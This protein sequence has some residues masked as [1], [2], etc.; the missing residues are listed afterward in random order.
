MWA[1][2]SAAD[3]VIVMTKLVAANPRRNRTTAFP[4]QRGNRFSSIRMLPWPNGLISATRLYIGSAPNTVTRTRISVAIGDS[5]P[6][7][8]KAMPGW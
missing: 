1:A 4:F 2:A 6:A 3:S 5:V 8:R 7:A